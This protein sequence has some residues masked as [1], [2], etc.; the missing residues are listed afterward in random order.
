MRICLV[1]LLTVI[2]ITVGCYGTADNTI[3]DIARDVPTMTDRRFE[4]VKLPQPQL[5]GD[6]SLEEALFRRRSVRE[7]ADAPLNLE[8]VSQLLWA[9]QGKTAAWGGRTSPSAGALYPLEIYLAAGNVEGLESG[10]FKY[11]SEG[12]ELA[13]IKAGDAREKLQ[14]VALG[15]SCIGEAAIDIVIAAVFERTAAKYGQRAERYVHMEAGHAAQNICLQATA[16]QLGAVP[17][18]AFNDKGV[19]EI[20][21]L[22]ADEAPLYILPVGRE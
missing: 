8:E 14:A 1:L 20:I 4:T 11:I 5:S 12:H 6:M 22:S 7:Y 17:I 18:G 2:S 16:M 15:Q 3:S 13:A 9:A 19:S 10:I 21:S